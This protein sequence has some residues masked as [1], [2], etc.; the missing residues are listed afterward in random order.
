LVP[1]VITYNAAISA[2]ERGRQPERAVQLVVEMQ[3]QELRPDAITYNT[4]MS[5][6]EKG[7]LPQHL[8]QLMDMRQRGCPSESDAASALIPGDASSDAGASTSGSSGLFAGGD[9]G[10]CGAGVPPGLRQCWDQ[11]GQQRRRPPQQQR[12]PKACAPPE[13][14]AAVNQRP[15]ERHPAVSARDARAMAD[16]RASMLAPV[17]PPRTCFQSPPHDANGYECDM[18][19]TAVNGTLQILPGEPWTMPAAP[20]G[21][22]E[23]PGHA[24]YANGNWPIRLEVPTDYKDYKCHVDDY[25]F[26][27]QQEGTPHEEFQKAPNNYKDYKCHADDYTFFRQQ[28]GTP[29]EVAKNGLN[30]FGPLGPGPAFVRPDININIPHGEQRPLAPV[31]GD[32]ERL[33]EASPWAQ[34]YPEGQV[35]RFSF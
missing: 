18:L 1:D 6:C 32:I 21:P 4:A 3:A 2:C 7:H 20:S 28:E 31:D 23:M 24:I 10:T 27:R 17:S 19:A 35:L 34:V 13:A 11:A 30:Y 5:A 8:Q 26:F 25:T 29:L 16:S 15:G 33:L 14:K 12:P 22:R 9:S